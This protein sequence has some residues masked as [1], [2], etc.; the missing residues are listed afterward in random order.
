M[1]VHA[2]HCGVL[3]RTAALQFPENLPGYITTFNPVT[4][5][6]HVP[7]V[8]LN[9]KAWNKPEKGSRSQSFDWTLLSFQPVGCRP[10]RSI[11]AYSGPFAPGFAPDFGFTSPY[12]ILPVRSDRGLRITI[13]TSRPSAFEK[14]EK[15]YTNGPRDVDIARKPSVLNRP[16]S[17]ASLERPQTS[18]I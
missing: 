7:D 18:P 2:G 6:R 5:A 12:W 11:L 17:L 3:G 15:P 16:V 10:F 13:S 8:R 1:A 14:C 4:P 9:G